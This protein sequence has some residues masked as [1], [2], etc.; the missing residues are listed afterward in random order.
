MTD[1]LTR[2]LPTIR[3]RARR[4]VGR[5]ASLAGVVAFVAGAPLAMSATPSGDKPTMHVGD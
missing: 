2:G 5:V 3:R 4:H 1:A